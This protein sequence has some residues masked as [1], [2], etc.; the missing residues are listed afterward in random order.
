MR[1]SVQPI[2][3]IAGEKITFAGEID[4]N[5]IKRHGE[6]VFPGLL[7]VSGEV[8][9]RAGVVVLRYQIKGSMPLECDRCLMQT[10]RLIDKKFEHTVVAQ[11]SNDD[12]DDAFINVPDGVL[13]IDEIAASDL[14]LDLPQI[15]LCKDDCKGLCPIC[16]ADLNYNNCGCQSD[17]TDPRMQK[18]RNLLKN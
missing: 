4:F 18:L 5:W 2:L 8:E 16:G 3:D 11:T 13:D 14:Q 12:T 15:F 6:S 9:N 10:D 17:S 1:L 7:A